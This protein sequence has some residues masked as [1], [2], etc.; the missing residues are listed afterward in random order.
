MPH[1][2]AL[3][4]ARAGSKGVPNKNVRLLNGHPLLAFSIKAGTLTRGI[5]RTLVSTDSPEYRE[6]GLRYG[7]EV[8]FLR[9][10]GIAGD[11]ATD[12]QYV[13]HALDWLE[14]EGEPVPD[15]IVQ[16]RPTTPLR[17]PLLIQQALAQMTGDPA[18]TALRSI[19]E[20]SETAYKCFEV[21]NGRLKCIGSG[22]FDVEEANRPR[23]S[24]PATYHANGYVDILRTSFIRQTNRL[25]G[26]RVAAFVTPR[27]VEVDTPEDFAELEFDMRRKADLFHVLFP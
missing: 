24:F 7:A 1:V 21:E 10:A 25:H 9:P 22:S 8:P 11:T 5:D 26:D 27:T 6:I 14:G 4:P 15:F 23:Q 20:M 12:L 13:T 19:H 18:P 17:D 3:I 16:L 2:V